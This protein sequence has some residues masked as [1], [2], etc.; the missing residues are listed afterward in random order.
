MTHPRLCSFARDEVKREWND[1]IPSGTLRS[2][3]FLPKIGQEQHE[4]CVFGV[5]DPSNA[6]L[7]RE[8]KQI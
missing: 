4:Q 5:T 7:M 3:Y 8:S 2:P 6:L 1:T